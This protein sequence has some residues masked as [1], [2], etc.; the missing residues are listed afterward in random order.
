MSLLLSNLFMLMAT[1]SLFA[2]SKG[3]LRTLSFELDHVQKPSNSK[4]ILKFIFRHLYHN[5]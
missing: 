3:D 2:W 1:L 5:A 4:K